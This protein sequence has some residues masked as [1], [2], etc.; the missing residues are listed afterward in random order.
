MQTALDDERSSGNIFTLEDVQQLIQSSVQAA[1]DNERADSY[2]EEQVQQLINQNVQEAIKTERERL[3]T[4]VQATDYDENETDKTGVFATAATRGD[5]SGEQAT[6]AAEAVKERLIC[7]ICCQAY[8]E[9]NP[10]MISMSGPRECGHV[11]CESCARQYDQK[12][13]HER[14]CPFGC[15]REPGW[16]RVRKRVRGLRGTQRV[17]GLHAP[18]RL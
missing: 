14:V 11:V 10:K 8:G 5:D 7:A 18:L 12:E 3:I 13:E 6:R 16:M 2:T 15:R 1:L 4:V 17:R 9:E